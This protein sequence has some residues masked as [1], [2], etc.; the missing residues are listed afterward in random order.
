MPV[1]I[2]EQNRGRNKFCSRSCSA[3]K[4]HV[5]ED[6]FK[7]IDSDEKAYWL[8]FIYADGNIYKNIF[9]LEIQERDSNHLKK[10]RR[11][12]NYTGKITKRYVGMN[13]YCRLNFSRKNFVNNLRKYGLCDNKSF[14]ILYPTNI[15][16]EFNRSFIRGVFDGDGCICIGKNKN[17]VWKITSGSENF[18]LHCKNII[19]KETGINLKIYNRIRKSPRKVLYDLSCFSKKIIKHIKDY[20]YN[21]SS[22]FLERKHNKIL[23][24]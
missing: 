19:E 24:L 11:A 16:K 18:L 22:V 6:Y 10:F 17:I 12:L 5:N 23:L 1:I 15:P 4:H 21:N 14:K 13:L 3:S 8:G 9:G 20:L 2:A 7:E